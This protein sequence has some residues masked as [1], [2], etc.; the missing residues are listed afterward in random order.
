MSEERREEYLEET[1]EV[2]NEETREIVVDEEAMRAMI[3]QYIMETEQSMTPKQKVSKGF[4]YIKGGFIQ[5]VKEH[6]I[7]WIGRFTGL[8]FIILGG[9]YYLIT[10]NADGAV[11]VVASGAVDGVTDTA[12]DIA[13]DTTA[14]VVSEVVDT[15]I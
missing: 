10:R 6:K 8:G 7:R 12:T 2:T 5:S 4:G 3:E 14:E 11:E 15:V 13:A 9:I 1:T